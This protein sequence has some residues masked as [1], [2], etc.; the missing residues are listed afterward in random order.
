MKIKSLGALVIT[1]AICATLCMYSYTYL[2]NK[3]KELSKIVDYGVS[4]ITL[5]SPVYAEVADRIDLSGKWKSM[6]DPSDKGQT[7]G[8][9]KPDWNDSAWEMVD[10]PGRPKELPETV[11]GYIWYRK[12]ITIPPE[13]KDK[14]FY[15]NLGKISNQDWTFFNGHLIGQVSTRSNAADIDRTYAVPSNYIK[16]GMPNT[17]ALRIRGVTGIILEGPVSLTTG[18]TETS[19]QKTAPKGEINDSIRLTGDVIVEKGQTVN[20]AIAVNGDVRVYGLVTGEATAVMGDVVVEP[21]GVVEGSAVAVNGKVIKKGNGVVKGEETS[22]G[23]RGMKNLPWDKN[24]WQMGILVGLGTMIASLVLAA[25]VVAL[26]PKRMLT[27]ADTATKQTGKS[28]LY[29]LV[30]LLLGLSAA[31]VLTITIVGIPLMALLVILILVAVVTGHICVG[32][33][34]GRKLF[35]AFDKPQVTVLLA[36]VVGVLALELVKMVPVLGPIVVFVFNLIGFGAIIITGFGSDSNWYNNRFG[37]KS[38]G[39]PEQTYSLPN[40]IE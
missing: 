36:A 38:S 40:D 8:W 10:L 25:M 30:G 20:N 11:F 16:Y 19:M 18:D 35:E 26:F 24:N 21:G 29:G 9:Y 4:Q 32:I 7:S 3:Y 27:T 31:I 39:K 13:L 1:A 14:E 37:R 6:P 23:W 22:V 2:D 34:I 28:A 17:I 15:L 33:A 5:S 12:S